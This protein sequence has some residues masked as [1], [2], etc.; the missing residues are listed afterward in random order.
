MTSLLSI[1]RKLQ[2]TTQKKINNCTLK[3]NIDPQSLSAK[4]LEIQ[5]SLISK[6][7]FLDLGSKGGASISYA[8]T[9]LGGKMGLGIELR[10]KFVAEANKAGRY[11]ILGDATKLQFPDKCVNFVVMSHFL[12]HLPDLQSTETVIKSSARVAKDFLFI[13]GPSFDDDEYLGNLGLKLFYS[14]WSGHPVKL[15][16]PILI[17]IL[18][19]MELTDYK[20]FFH[21]FILDSD[22]SAIHPAESPPDQHGYDSKKHPPKVKINF[23][24]K[25]P[26]EMVCFV[27]LRKDITLPQVPLYET[28]SYHGL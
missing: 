13:K 7:D 20:L 28:R 26:Q 11:C 4:D 25:I 10:K 24:H 21:R 27:K 1:L 12:E 15:A 19:R 2:G 8:K 14:D 23:D 16:S 17:D 3:T 5:P 6:F 9:H 22:D 18:K